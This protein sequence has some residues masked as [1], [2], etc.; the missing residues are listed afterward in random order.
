MGVKIDDDFTGGDEKSAGRPHSAASQLVELALDRYHFGVAEEGQPY[1][2][3]PGRH[4]VRM[5]R[6]GKNSLRA[7][8]SKAYYQKH[9]KA[10]PQHALADALLVLEGMAQDQDPNQVHLRVAAADG[11]VWLDLGDA[12]ETVVR[13]DANGWQV[14]R[15]GVPV[16]FRRTGLAGAL[17]NPQSASNASHASHNSYLSL[18]TFDPLWWHVNVAA[19]DRPL[20]LACLIAALTDPESPHP[21]LSLFGEQ[22]TG[23]STGCRRL[24]SLI[25]PS[26]VPLRKPPRDPEGWVTAAQG[27]WVVALDNLS[28]VPDWLS[29]SLCRAA[30]GDG[31]VRRALY[32]DSDLAVFAFRRCIIL[33]GIDVGALRGD[34]ADRTL[35]INL[36]RI[37]ESAR[38]TERQLNE[39]WTQDQPRIFGDL[40]SLAASLIKR[41]PSVR[42]ASSPRMADFARTL[43]AVDQILGTNGLIRFAE[44]ART[45]AEDTLSS[46]PFISAMA[47]AR[48]DFH[49]KSADLL[50]KITPD[51]QGWRPPRNWPKDPRM[52][53]SLLRRNAPAMR[54]VGWVVEE[55]EDLHYNHAIWTVISPEIGRKSG[56]QDS[57]DDLCG[58]GKPLLAPASRQRGSCESCW[59]HGDEAGSA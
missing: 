27:S 5:L 7:E 45:M 25:D 14:V 18:E 35:P 41:L 16:L 49:G 59:L 19:T 56:S 13:I 55:G 36:D 21:I 11:V 39:R 48:I 54:K 2:V 32:T 38:L 51:E 46:D 33:N 44:R 37:E 12:A 15:D 40:L 58:C 20:V 9:K 23:K 42:L 6:G 53:T 50:I 22:G 3:K 28:T 30:T 47:E 31:D 29:D 4:V 17:P 1:A 52:V 8:L 34:L 26:P 57:Q 24:I 43:A 10:A